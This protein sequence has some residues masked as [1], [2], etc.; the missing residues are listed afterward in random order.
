VADTPEQVVAAVH[1]WRS[2]IIAAALPHVKR[3]GDVPLTLVRG[4]DAPAQETDR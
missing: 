2:S 4:A 1:E 3:R